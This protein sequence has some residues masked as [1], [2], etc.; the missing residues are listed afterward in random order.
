MSARGERLLLQS[1]NQQH[2]ERV[3][4]SSFLTLLLACEPLTT[5][6]ACV[7]SVIG[8]FAFADGR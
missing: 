8:C 7:S 1:N 5:P 2:V 6:I 3:E 4:N